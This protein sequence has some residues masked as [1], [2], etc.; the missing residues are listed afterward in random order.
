MVLRTWSNSA[1]A[2]N[3]I[4]SLFHHRRASEKPAVSV[5]LSMTLD[6]GFVAGSMELEH[7]FKRKGVHLRNLQRCHRV[8]HQ[9]YGTDIKH[10][11]DKLHRMLL[12]VVNDFKPEFKFTASFII[13]SMIGTELHNYI[14]KEY[15][16][17]N[18]F[19][20]L[21]GPAL[22]VAKFANH[23]SEIQ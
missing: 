22:A 20:Q 2:N 17:D 10:S 13:D 1:S 4:D 14:F 19:Q 12:L 15:R 11:M 9:V 18:P 16:I 5:A 3:Y 6:V 21:L 8:S 23:I 7:A